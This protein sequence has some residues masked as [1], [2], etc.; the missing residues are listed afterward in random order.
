VKDETKATIR[1]LPLDPAP[2]DGECVVCGARAVDD[3]TWAQA[4]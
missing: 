4:Y 1:Y 3:A 2:V